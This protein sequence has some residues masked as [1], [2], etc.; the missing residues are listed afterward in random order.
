MPTGKLVKLVH[1]S[2]QTNAP[3]SRLI[4][5]RNDKGYGVI[6]DVEGR[7][8]YFSHEMVPHLHGF[9]DLRKG[10]QVEFTL[11]D[12]GFLRATSVWALKAGILKPAA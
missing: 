7:E 11:E 12:E 10:Q 3:N 6:E 2:Q 1:L 4:P 5:G 9:D 8:I